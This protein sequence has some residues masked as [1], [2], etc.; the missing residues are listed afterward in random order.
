MGRRKSGLE[1]IVGGLTS[2][3]LIWG[4]WWFHV[5]PVGWALGLGAVFVVFPILGG[6]R[7]VAREVSDSGQRRREALEAAQAQ[8]REH[9]DTL[10]KQVI[11][12]AHERRGVVTPALVVLHTDLRLEE[13]EK[14]LETLAAR[15]HAQMRIKDNG[16]IDYVF[17]ELLPSGSE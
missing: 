6:L 1:R 4:L 5:L 7:R 15:G 9:R 17:P 10:E 16:T 2:G 3:A 13:A 14:V 12:V 8:E 11:R